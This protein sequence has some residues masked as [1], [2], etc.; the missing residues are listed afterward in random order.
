[1]D[2]GAWQ[3][4]VHRVA[5]SS[6]KTE[7]TEHACMHGS[8]IFSFLRNL[9]TVFWV[10]LVAQMIKNLPIIQETWV[11]F[12]GQED[13]VGEEMATNS[14]ILVWKIPLDRE[15]WWATVHGVGKTRTWLSRHSLTHGVGSWAG[16]Q[17]ASRKTTS[18]EQSDAKAEVVMETWTRAMQ[19][20]AF[21]PALPGS[22]L[23]MQTLGPRS[24]L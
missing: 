22:L 13:P 14:S 10:P 8:S 15:A 1:M 18:W 23:E 24:D 2:R 7:A 21:G 11:W 12:L 20:T 4:T 17:W 6:D 16:N 19:I 3:A 5:K 9:H